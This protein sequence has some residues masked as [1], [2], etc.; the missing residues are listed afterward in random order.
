MSQYSDRSRRIAFL[1]TLLCAAVTAASWASAAENSPAGTLAS[2]DSEP[3]EE[4][5]VTAEKRSTD[6]QRTPISMTAIGGKSLDEEQ[7]R[8]LTDIA[9]LAPTFKMGETDGYQQITIRGIGISNFTPGFDSAV[10]VNVNGVYVS[11]PVAQ[12][13]SFFD[14]SQI[15]VLRGPQ[16][17]LYGRNAS[18]GSVN[19]STTLPT[20]DFSGYGKVIVGNYHDVDVEGAIGGALVP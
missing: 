10:A 7:V 14:V 16:G 15:E 8:S 13:T 6:L 12:A 20:N 17:T 5:V 19:I 4:I 18:A 3:L 9:S 1:G 11:R 2:S